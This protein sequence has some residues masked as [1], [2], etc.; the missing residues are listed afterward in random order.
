ML[1]GFT[2]GK[3]IKYIQT[4]TIDEDERQRIMDIVL[5]GP[6]SNILLEMVRTPFNLFK[7]LEEEQN[8]EIDMNK[9]CR[10]ISK[11]H[12]QDADS[13]AYKNFCKDFRGC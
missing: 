10:G 8:K 7:L 9:L 11:N 6:N 2:N 1:E 12:K 4:N 3:I 5:K 13:E